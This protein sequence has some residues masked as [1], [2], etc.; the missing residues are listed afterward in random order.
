MKEMTPSEIKLEASKLATK[1]WCNM[2]DD[3]C[4]PRIHAENILAREL[5][6]VLSDYVDNTEDKKYE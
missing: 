1:I 3:F 5:E 2:T 4:R 6:K